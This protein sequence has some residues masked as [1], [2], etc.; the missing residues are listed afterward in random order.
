[1]FFLFVE[2]DKQRLL[3]Q[4]AQLAEELQLQALPVRQLHTPHSPWNQFAATVHRYEQLPTLAYFQLLKKQNFSLFNSFNLNKKKK[5][6]IKF[7]NQFK[8]KSKNTVRIQK[9][10]QS[11]T[12]DE[13]TSNE[14]QSDEVCDESCHLDSLLQQ[15]TGFSAESRESDDY[16]DNSL[17]QLQL[18]SFDQTNDV[19]DDGSNQLSASNVDYF[20]SENSFDYEPSFQ[21][22]LNQHHPHPHG[23]HP[24]HTLM[25]NQQHSLSVNLHEV[26]TFLKYAKVFLKKK[27]TL[28]VA[29]HLFKF[30]ARN[31]LPLAIRFKKATF[32][33]FLLKV[34]LDLLLVPLGIVTGL[35]PLLLPFAP[36]SMILIGIS[37]LFAST[38]CFLLAL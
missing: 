30:V 16:E 7:L 17:D 3:Q 29:V 9:R 4:F 27:L 6:K 31:L 36:I 35:N 8:P 18:A 38:I 10:M 2:G 14:T 22:H 12:D 25:D 1:M 5:F 13:S 21:R 24:K 32:K 26:L 19:V 33:C 15:L 23:Y 34:P 20:Q 37:K 11:E 28:R